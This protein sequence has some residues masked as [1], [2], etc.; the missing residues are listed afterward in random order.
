MNT[1]EKVELLG[2]IN[3]LRKELSECL[4]LCSRDN[5]WSVSERW[6]ARS[7]KDRSVPLGNAAWRIET[8]TKNCEGQNVYVNN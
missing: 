1:Q 2:K 4:A 8:K 6:I 5:D 3:R 7:P